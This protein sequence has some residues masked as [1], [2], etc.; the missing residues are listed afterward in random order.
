MK[1]VVS[2]RMSAGRPRSSAL[3]QPSPNRPVQII[4]RSLVLDQLQHF[5][6]QR[7]VTIVGKV[8]L[9]SIWH[10]PQ[11]SATEYMR[12]LRSSLGD[13]CAKGEGGRCSNGSAGKD[14]YEASVRLSG[15]TAVIAPPKSSIRGIRD[16]A[17]ATEKVNQQMR[18][19]STP[20]ELEP[21]PRDP[22][23]SQSSAYTL[24]DYSSFPLQ[25]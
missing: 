8:H 11:I 21:S 22:P 13:Q 24:I 15:Y 3:V 9:L 14:T 4:L 1:S 23:A 6:N 16:S 7:E 12:Q 20:L 10:L 25:P 2:F 17:D 5:Q 19:G 18:D